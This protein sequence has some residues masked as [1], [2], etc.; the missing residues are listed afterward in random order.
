M[1]NGEHRPATIVKVWGDTG[2][3]NL[4]VLTDGSND[5]GYVPEDK[6]LLSDFG[7][8]PEDVKHGHFW[9]TSVSHDQETKAPN[10]WH[11]IERA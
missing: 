3:S 4:I 2:T 9:K 8:N 10:T 6:R 1:P 5:S 7:I 11:W